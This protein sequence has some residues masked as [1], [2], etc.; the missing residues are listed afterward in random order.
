MVTIPVTGPHLRPVESESREEVGSGHEHFLKH[1]RWF[2][3][4]QGG[5]ERALEANE[6]GR[7]VHVGGLH[8]SLSAPAT[9]W[10]AC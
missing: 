10:G 6:G 5:S 3:A 8:P 4:G 2:H 7:A 9:F 1:L